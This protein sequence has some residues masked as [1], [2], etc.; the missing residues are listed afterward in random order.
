MP[1]NITLMDRA[2]AVL[3]QRLEDSIYTVI[4]EPLKITAYCT[5]EPVTYANKT[6]GE[7]KVLKKGE[8]WGDLFDCAWFNFTGTVPNDAQEKDIVLLIDVSGEGCIF[9]ENGVPKQGITNKASSFSLFYGKPGKRVH[10]ILS[11]AKG[12][13]KIDVWMDAGLNDLFGNLI[14]NGAIKEADIAVRNKKVLKLYYDVIVLEELSRILPQNQSRTAQIKQILYDV[15][16]MI[17]DLSDK[18]VDKAS[19]ILEPFLKA[20]N[21]DTNLTLSVIGHSH[22]DLAWLWPIRET[23]R[24]GA[25]TFST[26]MHFFDKYPDYKFVQSQA[27][28]YDWIKEEYPELYKKIKTK[29]KEGKWE[30]NGAMWVEPDCNMPSGESFV[31]QVLYAQRFFQD[32]F[33]FTS[34]VCFLPDTFGYSAA[35]PQILRQC[36]VKYFTTQKISWNTVNKF[37]YHSFIWQGMDGTQILSHMLPEENY[38]SSAM[39]RAF[40]KNEENYF[41]KGLSNNA[42]ML[43]GI[44][45]G[46]GGPGEEHIELIERQKNLAGEI[47]CV[48]ESTSNF[49]KKL[50]KDSDK[51]PTW[52][53]EMYLEFHQGTLTSQARNKKW[54]RFME[55]ALR[56]TEILSVFAGISAEVD[57]KE[58]ELEKVWKE[59]LLYQFHDIL[60]GSSI[61]RVYEE[62]LARYEILFKETVKIAESAR[63]SLYKTINTKSFTKPFIAENTLSWEREELV[64]IEKDKWVLATA[65]SMGYRVAEIEDADFTSP[66]VG[67]TSVENDVIKVTFAKDGSIK[68]IFD[69]RIGKET[70]KGVGNKLLI[71]ED[72]NDAWDMYPDYDLRNKYDLEL[73]SSETK[74]NGPKATVTQIYK[75]NSSTIT[76]NISII[77]GSERV[78]F[79]THVDWK[80]SFK[81]LRT[82]FDVNV[83]SDFSRSEIQFGNIKRTNNTNTSWDAAKFEI[84][85]HKWIDLSDRSYG[86]ALINNCKYGH[87]VLGNTINLNLLRSTSHPDPNADKA[88]H[89]FRYAFFPHIGDYVEAELVK[90]AYEF[91]VPMNIN[92]IDVH[93]GVNE[94]EKSYITACSDHVII[95]TVKK[96]ED[97]DNIIVRLYECHETSFDADVK[98]GFDI[99]K[100]YICNMMEEPEIELKV[101][102][103]SVTIETS[104]FK[105]ITLM[106]EK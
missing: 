30:A 41:E 100:A 20:Q 16:M 10:P 19:K 94:N 23:K 45:D 35:L 44:G 81:M 85:A 58:E 15:A 72:S 8:T 97:S 101:K 93:V 29:V 78:D 102:N 49:F 12:G 1:T 68:S 71:Y 74:V 26:V 52:V 47:G 83:L 106:I 17:T 98:F 24:K 105:V 67:K 27:Q 37:P 63:K 82:H 2:N 89:E 70:L 46:G 66:K 21:G 99:K 31:R 86:T 32:E 39:P 33:G 4:G 95:D 64:E 5:K 43:F 56:N 80:E 7:K 40:K 60:P 34:D 57:Y 103:N 59:V 53:G 87:R 22:L 18:E 13:E 92:K 104:P 61:G 48:Q 69:K 79:D 14:D 50:E 65:P 75:Y 28:L 11:K 62:S 3:V 54:N 6:S 90:E 38:L 91:N 42:L 76:Q 88:E 9:D 55:L 25:R 73:I 96:A 84:C 51:F 36:K 77:F